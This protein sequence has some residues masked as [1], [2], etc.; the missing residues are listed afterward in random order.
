[1]LAEQ[2]QSLIL[3]LINERGAAT[4][5]EIQRK[6]KVSRETIRRDILTLADR[7]AVHRTHGG[8]LSLKQSEPALAAREEI[9]AEGKRIIG[10]LAAG[11]IPNGASVMLGGG[12][13]VQ[14]VADA[15]LNHKGLTI[16]TN[17][18]ANC[19]KLTGRNDNRV[20]MIGGAM[21][22]ANMTALG[23]DATSMMARY[24]ADFAVVGAGAISPSGWVTD[25]TTEEADLYSLM[26]RS[27]N[28]PIVVAD[29]SKFN[30]QVAVR[31]VD[32]QAVRYLLTD[33]QPVTPLAEV[34]SALP[35]EVVVGTT[36]VDK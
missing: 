5:T 10:N 13:T 30:K 11:I 36:A 4:I 1:V 32:L 26:L 33:R 35:L 8:A 15:L 20:Y 27:A 18:L 34:L 24:F 3:D 19:S 22:T 28:V 23:S 9:N 2:R 16:Y 7:N 17:S 12:S 25:Y 31:I 21:Q 6:L 29:H 14:A